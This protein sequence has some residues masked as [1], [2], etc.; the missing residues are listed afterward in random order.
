LDPSHPWLTLADAEVERA[1]V[2]LELVD[3]AA[4]GTPTLT[5]APRRERASFSNFDA[6]SLGINVAMPFG[7]RAH[8][9]VQTA[10]AVRETAQAEAD[11]AELLR[12]LDLD[13]HEARH[14]LVV[15]NASLE[16]ARERYELAVMSLRMGE[17]AFTQ[18][19]T[20]LFE[21]L[22]WEETARITQREAESL[23]IERQ[24][25]IAQVNQA[26]GEWP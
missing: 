18:G 25:A 12:R 5:I 26:L 16:L 17:N 2:E 9:T 21:L 7:G 6:D 24:R 20:T 10:A 19:E 13:L 14:G 23:E 15:V 11:R 8:R 22:R 4:R 1:R 3:R